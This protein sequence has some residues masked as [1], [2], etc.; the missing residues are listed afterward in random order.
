MEVFQTVDPVK[1]MESCGSRVVVTLYKLQNLKVASYS[2][3]RKYY[4]LKSNK[5]ITYIS[6]LD[7]FLYSQSS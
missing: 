3:S 1:F 6:H 5:H 4:R 2:S 7:S